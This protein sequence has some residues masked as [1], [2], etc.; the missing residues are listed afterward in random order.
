MS[1]IKGCNYDSDGWTP[2]VGFCS[3]GVGTE[4]SQT[5]IVSKREMTPVDVT[6]AEAGAIDRSS[7]KSEAENS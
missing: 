2:S 6:F 4:N 1:S 7:R 3:Q 5:K